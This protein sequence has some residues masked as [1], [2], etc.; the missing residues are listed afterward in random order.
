MLCLVC[1]SKTNYFFSKKY[2]KLPYSNMMEDIGEV[3][4]YK[5][6]NCGFTISKTHQELD[7]ERFE[8]LNSI[9]CIATPKK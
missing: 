4:Y 8:N 9:L 6:E 5:C 2:N 1:Q 3:E 7:N